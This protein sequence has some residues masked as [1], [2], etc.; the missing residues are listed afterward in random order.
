[1]DDRSG[2]SIKE[3]ITTRW[4]QNFM[5]TRNIV[6]LSQTAK[7]VMSPAKQELIERSVAYHLGELQR[8][9][10]SG[11][12]NDEDVCNAEEKHFVINQHDHKTLARRGDA[13]VKYADVVN[14]DDGMTMMVLLQGGVRSAVL[15]PFIILKNQQRNY[16]IRNVLDNILGVSYR[17]QPNAW[18]DGLIFLE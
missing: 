16:P 6:S 4:V 1:M 15:P 12:L 18:M 7:L 17:T 3:H 10:H 2:K 9:F 13:D 14:G 8:E 11:A 5:Q